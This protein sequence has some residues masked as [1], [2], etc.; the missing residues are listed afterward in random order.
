MMEAKNRMKKK[1]KKKK[2]EKKVRMMT[3]FQY[4]NSQQPEYFERPEIY[5]CKI[6]RQNKETLIKSNCRRKN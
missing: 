3:K 4:N 1:K 5:N 2:K 6:K